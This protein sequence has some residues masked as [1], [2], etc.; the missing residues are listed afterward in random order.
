MARFR[1]R[2]AHEATAQEVAA[3]TLVND[4]KHDPTSDAAAVTNES[5]SEP[6]VVTED[7]QRGV[8]KVEAVALTWSK[9]SLVLIF[10][11]YVAHKP[12]PPPHSLRLLTASGRL[13]ARSIASP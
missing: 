11:L 1:F 10:T 2:R 8:Q 3:D 12:P 4:E 9:K 13:V 7:A 6:D 5:G